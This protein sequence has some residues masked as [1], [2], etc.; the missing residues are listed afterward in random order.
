MRRCG[1]MHRPSTIG[2]LLAI[3]LATLVAG[4]GLGG[5][6]EPTAPPATPAPTGL[7]AGDYTTA[8]FRPPVTASLPDGWRIA[9]DEA[10]YAAL[11]PATSDVVGIHLFRSPLPASQASDCP[12]EAVPD[13]GPTAADLVAWIRGRPGL[14]TSEPQP[15]SIGGLSGLMLDAGIVSGWSPS[16]PFAN[17][18]PTVPLF[19]SATPG[20][21]RWV[22]AGSERLRL[23]VF[24]VPGDGTV[25]VDIDDFDGSFMD[26]F[27]PE[28]TPIVESLRFGLG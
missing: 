26:S 20:N 2:A 27:L 17:G 9:A 4:C 24:D 5:T 13:V 28:A 10:D 12:Q 21:Y 8:S 16:C 14:V 3:V 19:V 18:L 23:Y 7:T 6:P 1:A 15:V 22:V 25:V 11:G